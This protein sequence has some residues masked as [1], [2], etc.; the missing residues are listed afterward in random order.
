MSTWR[1]APPSSPPRQPAAPHPARTSTTWVCF[2]PQ[3]TPV[4]S[5]ALPRWCNRANSYVV[6]FQSP[7]SASSRV[8]PWRS[9]DSP[10]TYRAPT[11]FPETATFRVTTTCCRYEPAPPTAKP[12]L[13]PAAPARCSRPP[14]TPRAAHQAS[15]FSLNR[16]G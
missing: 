5:G 11:T 7:R 6:L 1:P 9:R 8:F 3:A 2:R 14:R 12:R 4:Q 10:G 13:C 15:P 16:R